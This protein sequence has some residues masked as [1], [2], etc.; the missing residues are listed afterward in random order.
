[1]WMNSDAAMKGADSGRGSP[2]HS[3]IGS[4]T[5]APMKCTNAVSSGLSALDLISTFQPAC[6]SA[7]S[8]TAA[9][10]GQ[11]SVNKVR[12]GWRAR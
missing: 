7:P 4:A 5:N 9:I 11:V 10:R 12:S 8:S 1:M 3:S 2:T 6:S